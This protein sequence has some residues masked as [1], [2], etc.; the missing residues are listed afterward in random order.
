MWW[1]MRSLK[2]YENTNQG[3]HFSRRSLKSRIFMIKLYLP[4]VVIQVYNNRAY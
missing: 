1:H 4:D 2:K 3:H